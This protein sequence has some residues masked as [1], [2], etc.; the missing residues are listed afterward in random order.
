MEKQEIVKQLSKKYNKKEK[1]IKCM[2]EE[3]IIKDKKSLNEAQKI[4]KRFF[5]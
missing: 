2:I 5:T 3:L 1:L 4:V